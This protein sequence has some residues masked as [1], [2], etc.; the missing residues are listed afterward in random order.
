[1]ADLLVTIALLFG[2]VSCLCAGA[3]IVRRRGNV[4]RQRAREHGGTRHGRFT[5]RYELSDLLP[6]R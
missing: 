5:M 6:P 1:M 3:L 4:C 2:L